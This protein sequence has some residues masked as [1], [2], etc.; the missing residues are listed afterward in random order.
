MER[1]A[2][3][4]MPF[5]ESGAGRVLLTIIRP[6]VAVLRETR[7]CKMRPFKASTVYG[8]RIGKRFLDS[9]SDA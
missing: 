2:K 9:L 1:F 8:I 5:R 6:I 3:V 7:E 4:G